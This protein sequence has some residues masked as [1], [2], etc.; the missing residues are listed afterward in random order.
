[1]YAILLFDGFLVLL[2]AAVITL[3]IAVLLQVVS[4][5]VVRSI[6]KIWLGRGVGSSSQVKEPTPS[7]E[8]L[9]QIKHLTDDSR[10][11]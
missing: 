11:P 10:N 1:M 9:Q 8:V 5:L 4:L 6:V 7:D 3:S 2:V